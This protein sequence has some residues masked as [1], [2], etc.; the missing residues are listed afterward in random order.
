MFEDSGDQ[1]AEKDDCNGEFDSLTRRSNDSYIKD[2]S[3]G[4]I[5]G[6]W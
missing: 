1:N 4:M 3:G 6:R 2:G 5:D